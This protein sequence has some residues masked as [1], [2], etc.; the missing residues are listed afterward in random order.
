MLKIDKIKNHSENVFFAT[1]M[2]MEARKKASE[3]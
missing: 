2:M 3:R 1:Y